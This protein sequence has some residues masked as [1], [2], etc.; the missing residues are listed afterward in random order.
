MITPATA[1]ATIAPGLPG[2]GASP[3]GGEMF[4]LSMLAVGREADAA[5]LPAMPAAAPVP[6]T[7]PVAPIE[8]GRQGFA[9]PGMPL[10]TEAV[11]ARVDPA[12]AW[13]AAVDIPVPA[14]LEVPPALAAVPGAEV[15]TVITPTPRSFRP[16]ANNGAS[17]MALA[18]TAPDAAVAPADPLSIAAAPVDAPTAPAT[19]DIPARQP[20][21]ATR[22]AAKTVERQPTPAAAMPAAAPALDS[23]PV[24][25]TVPLITSVA[26]QAGDAPQAAPV[27]DA[28][29]ITPDA[30]TKR[31]AGKAEVPM[32][33]VRTAA[34]RLAEP[35]MPTLPEPDEAPVSASNQG[36][37][38]AV[39]VAV[40]TPALPRPDAVV[41]AQ[42]VPAPTPPPTPTPVIAEQPQPARRVALATKTTATAPMTP[43]AM[44]QV[45][46][47]DAAPTPQ[48]EASV[49]V[50]APMSSPVPAAP[51]AAPTPSAPNPVIDHATAA[52][53]PGKRS[54]DA[55]PVVAQ[56]VADIAPPPASAVPVTGAMAPVAA[57]V[58]IARSQPGG[59]ATVSPATTRAR[60]AQRQTTTPVPQTA[61]D[62]A[63]PTMIVDRAA[64]ATAPVTTVTAPLSS[65]I[66]STAATANVPPPSTL[67]AATPADAT[68]VT[69]ATQPTVAAPVPA[70]APAAI[71][72]AVAPP[73]IAAAAP[74]AVAG[75][76]VIAGPAPATPAPQPRA[77]VREVGGTVRQTVALRPQAAAL[78]QPPAGTTAPASQVFGAAI[79][80]AAGAD[81]R[82][83][84]EPVELAPTAAPALAPVVG[85]NAVVDPQPTLDL[86]QN[87]WP[88]A[89]IDHI[90]TLRDAANATDTRIRLVP[91]ALGVI[92]IAVKTVGD[93]IHVRFAAADAT[94]RTL[95]EEAQPRL[96]AIAEERGLRIG[97]TV[98]EAAP[99][100]QT[101]TGQPQGQASQSQ[102][103][104]GQSTGQS[105]G[106]SASGQP[107]ANQAQT[108]QQ[109]QPRQNQTSARQPASPPRAPSPHTDAAA[110]GRVA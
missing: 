69:P 93:A 81:E 35:V 32:R 92:D 83:A 108:G 25:T 22:P 40:D 33:G 9:A 66:A 17:V 18:A 13:L 57:P 106:Q 10:P 20:D 19:P 43:S 105:A 28:I 87:G 26:P 88:A 11:P 98:V 107:Q 94:T 80:A 91:D 7:G 84:A 68:P 96:A 62:P 102:S 76:P 75:A 29:V 59:G 3:A 24:V 47:R 67:A 41:I 82:R 44:P 71:P 109:Q 77:F 60:P 23:A 55:S 54:D 99:A 100:S 70:T 95:I 16:V 27:A 5:A 30:P 4:A 2:K 74:V 73:V 56:R 21:A 101:N 58:Q 42:A 85:G 46:A 15:A 36:D 14:P 53:P 86:R 51:A 45:A 63:P 31:T 64:V 1:V 52:P 61:L 78:P 103:S 110:D 90:E 89:M 50:T 8:T 97:Q 104:Q 48:T 34:P 39:P 79:H 38:A 49:P 37:E 65:P 72:T 12:L 6:M